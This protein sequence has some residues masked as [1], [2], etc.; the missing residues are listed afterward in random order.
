MPDGRKFK[1]VAELKKILLSRKP[2]F[3]RNLTEKLLTYATGRRMN[4]H[5]RP[6]IDR[7]VERLER[8]KLG[9]RDLVLL[10]VES[11]SFLAK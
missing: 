10:V 5:D 2:Q 9:L 8:D 3:A 11:D 1:D 4:V 6:H 7:V